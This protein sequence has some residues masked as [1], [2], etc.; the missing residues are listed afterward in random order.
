VRIALDFADTLERGALQVLPASHRENTLAHGV[1]HRPPRARA[2]VA[3]LEGQAVVT[4][5][6]PGGA[7]FYN[8]CE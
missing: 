3:A 2:V 5:H 8:P 7:L 4:A 1:N 6:R